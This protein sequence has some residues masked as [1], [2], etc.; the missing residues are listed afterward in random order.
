MTVPQTFGGSIDQSRAQQEQKQRTTHLDGV[1][2]AVIELDGDWVALWPEMRHKTTAALQRNLRKYYKPKNKP[3]LL[4]E[5]T[6]E[7]NLQEITDFEIDMSRF[8]QHEQNEILLLNQV[9]EWSFGPVTAEVLGN[10]STLKYDGL[11]AE[12]EKLYAET[13]LPAKA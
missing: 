3:V 13:P 4:S 8:D 7:T 10:I 2:L 11:M 12:V 9:V 1:Q 6:P 5:L